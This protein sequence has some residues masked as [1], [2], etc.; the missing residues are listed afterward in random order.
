M[1]KMFSFASLALISVISLPSY[2][3]AIEPE[4]YLNQKSFQVES[5]LI[6]QIGSQSTAIAVIVPQSIYFD[7]DAGQE[8][9]LTLALAQPITDMQGNVRVPVNSLVNARITST[10]GGGQIIAESVIVNGKVFPIRAVSAVIPSTE[11]TVND[12]QARAEINTSSLGRTGMAIGCAVEG[13]FGGECN[14]NAMRTGGS[15]GL[16]LGWV[17]NQENPETRQVV[18]IQQGSLF[19][20]TAQ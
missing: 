2:A 3:Y 20:L 5:N 15:I 14:S 9:P 10:N 12:G 4:S 17:S 8:V 18:Q 7:A 1:K 13:L 11:T 6:A 16:A 19:I